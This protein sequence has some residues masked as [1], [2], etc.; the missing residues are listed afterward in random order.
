MTI[1]STLIGL[2]LAV[3]GLLLWALTAPRIIIEKTITLLIL[4]AGLL[5]LLLLLVSLVLLLQRQWGWVCLALPVTLLYWSL[6]STLVSQKLMASLE[7]RYQPVQIDA[8]DAFDYLIVLGGGALQLSDGSAQLGQSGDRVM[9]AARLWHAG[10]VST[11][12]TTGSSLLSG[13]GDAPLL[14]G[15]TSGLWRDIGIP[16]QAIQMIAGRNT[17]EEMASVAELL[18]GQSPQRVGLLTSAWHLPRAMRLASARGLNLIAVPADFY[19]L[20]SAPPPPLSLLPQTDGIWQST[21]VVREL[22]AGIVRR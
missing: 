19:S 20:E 2:A 4:P 3:A 17:F 11:L 22:L 6:S 15:A 9:L 16:A 18:A 10:K 12:V 7:S 21:L 14:A 8:V 5:G 1:K 13:P